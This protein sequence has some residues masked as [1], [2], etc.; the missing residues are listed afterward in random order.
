MNGNAWVDH[1][2]KGKKLVTKD[3]VTHGDNRTA[4]AA[5][6]RYAKEHNVRVYD[7]YY[8]KYLPQQTTR[9]ARTTR[10][11]TRPNRGSF[12]DFRFP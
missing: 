9:A 6:I 12:F 8:G 7:K 1:G 10:Q 11:S 2:Y 4:R 5:A 3:L